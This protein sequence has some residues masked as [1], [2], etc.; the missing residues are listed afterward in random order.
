LTLKLV[1]HNRLMSGLPVDRT[2]IGVN[3]IHPM[4]HNFPSSNYQ[5]VKRCWIWNL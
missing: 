1:A 5:V 3:G 2:L 4:S